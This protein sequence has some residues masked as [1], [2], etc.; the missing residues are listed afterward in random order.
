MVT[1]KYYKIKSTNTT[2]TIKKKYFNKL[3]RV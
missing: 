2:D 3:I 1:I